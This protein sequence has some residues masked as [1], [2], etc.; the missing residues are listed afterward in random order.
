MIS[1]GLSTQSQ[2]VLYLMDGAGS[3][4]VQQQKHMCSIAAWSFLQPSL[5][6]THPELAYSLTIY[7]WHR[8]KVVLIL[9]GN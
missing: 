6:C 1:L 9:V 5:H 3:L 2:L 4:M 8:V 7:H